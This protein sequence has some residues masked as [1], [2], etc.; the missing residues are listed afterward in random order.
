MVALST[1]SEVRSPRHFLQ[2]PGVAIRVVE[3]SEFDASS[4]FLDY[5]HLNASSNQRIAC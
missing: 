4:V 3:M 5:T 1:S 2:R